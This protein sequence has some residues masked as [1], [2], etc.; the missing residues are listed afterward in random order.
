VLP[1]LLLLCACGSGGGSSKQQVT[2]ITVSGKVRYEDRHYESSGFTGASGM[3]PVRHVIM[4]LVGDQGVI[5]RTGTD[6]FGTYSLQGRGSGL[7]IRVLAQTDGS[8]SHRVEVVQTSTPTH[9]FAVRTPTLSNADTAVN[10]DITLANAGAVTG[11]FNIL[12]VYQSAGEFIATRWT[13]SLPLLQARWEECNTSGTYTGSTGIPTIIIIGLLGVHSNCPNL[14]DPL[15]SG[16]VDTDEYDDDVL[17]HEY[18]HYLEFA[19]DTLDSPGLP[20]TITEM[21]QDIRLSWSEG[22]SSFLSGSIKEWLAITHPERLSIATAPATDGAS[23]SSLYVD[24]FGAAAFSYDFRSGTLAG[25]PLNYATNE[26]AIA[27]ILWGIN[28]DGIFDFSTIWR[29]FSNHLS[30]ND[31]RPSSLEK[32]W[33]G[34]LSEFAPTD[35]DKGAMRTILRERKVHYENDA[36]ENDNLTT[37]AKPLR[38]EPDF[39]TLFYNNGGNADIDLIPFQVSSANTYRIET[40]NLH[41]GADTHLQILDTGGAVLAIDGGLLTNDNHTP[42]NIIP[43]SPNDTCRFS[44]R[45]EFN[46]WE[47][48]TYYAEIR[49]SPDHPD[50]NGRF[51]DYQLLITANPS[52][53]QERKCP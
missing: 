1:F 3:R 24:T 35:T 9:L 41:N 47:S 52:Q 42:I 23:P 51:G 46:A 50:T 31:A 4:E 30:I 40:Y 7:Y 11:V 13:G 33:D 32:V 6:D 5:S 53:S 45:I 16:G 39:Y 38:P 21:T 28:D 29:V 22:W 27:K 12:D 43:L 10:I 20:H 15:Y 8:I 26:G 44:S 34:W 18:G 37:E 36:S 17:W 14:S 25:I 19:F 49:S 2:E 48:S